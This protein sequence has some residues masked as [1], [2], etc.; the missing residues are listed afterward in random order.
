MKTQ[1]ETK[2]PIRALAGGV[3]LL[4]VLGAGTVQA[5]PHAKISTA[6]ANAIVLKRFPGKL[7][8]RTT[9]ENEEGTWQYGVMV[10]SGRTLRE[11][12]VDA[13]SG[14]IA[15]VEVTSTNKEKIEE[16]HEKAADR[17]AS[18]HAARLTQAQA[19]AVVLRR[20]PGK[21]AEAPLEHE[22]GKWQYGVLVRS[23]HTLRDVMVNAYSGKIESVTVTTMA[24]ERAEKQAEA[25]AKKTK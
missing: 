5:A 16:V 1:T 8:A 24:K 22:G 12:M 10:R 7:T 11:V 19:E 15:N 23:G 25:A 3:G 21:I 18:H 6:Q 20:F 2:S 9:L 14:A 13:G 4:A 17:K